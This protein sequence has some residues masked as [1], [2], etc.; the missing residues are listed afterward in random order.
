MKTKERKD[1]H[2]KSQVELRTML[3][4]LKDAV[5][6]AKLELSQNKLKN[7]RSIFLKRKEIAQ[8]LSILKEKEI[9]K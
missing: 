1:L 2:T 5:F 7:T 9:K 6:T 3:K 8:I 4:S